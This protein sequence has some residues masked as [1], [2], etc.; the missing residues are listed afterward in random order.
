MAQVVQPRTVAVPPTNGEAALLT[1]L[2]RELDDDWTVYVQPFLNGDEPD[3]V[4]LN[5]H[6]G[7][8]V[9]DVKDYTQGAYTSENGA[10]REGE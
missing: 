3:L 6:A 8:I 4:A 9:F 2:R 5:P 1:F 10:W 7:V